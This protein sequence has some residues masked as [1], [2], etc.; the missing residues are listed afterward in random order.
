MEKIAQ[1]IIGLPAILKDQPKKL[2]P[3]R[4]ELLRMKFHYIQD[5]YN[6]WSGDFSKSE[7]GRVRDIP[8]RK[9]LVQNGFF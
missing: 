4:F 6:N 8:E 7:E 1:E 5:F 9:Y 2:G 3:K